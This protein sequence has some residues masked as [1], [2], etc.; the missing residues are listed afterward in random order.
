VGTSWFERVRRFKSP[1]RVVSAFL[2]RSR[3]TRARKCEELKREID[4]LRQQA[5]AQIAAR[6]RWEQQNEELRQQVR[7]LNE[8]REEQAQRTWELP[9]DPPLGTHGFGARLISLAVNLA[10]RVGLRGAQAV[11]RIVWEWLGVDTKVPCWTSI[12]NGLQRLG[13]AALTKPV[14]RAEDWIWLADHSNQIGPEKVLVVLGVRASK[15]PEPGETLKHEDVRLLAVQPGTSWKTADVAATYTQLAEQ[16]G[17]PRAVV[18]D[19]AP[20]LQDGAD[21]LKIRRSDTI[22]LRDFKPQAANA[23]QAL[24]G[25]SERFA[26]FHTQGGQTRSAIQQTELAH[27]VPPTIRQKARFMN[28]QAVLRW[29]AC[30]LWLL[31]H[32]D[33]KSRR[34]FTS[35]RLEA[36][37]G[38][39]RSFASEI[40]LWNECQPVIST[41]L[42]FLN[43]RGLFHGVAAQLRTA[44]S[45]L[46]TTDTAREL[47]ERLLTFVRDAETQLQPNERLWLSTEI[48]EST[49]GLYKQLEGQHSQGGFT[50][51]IAAFGSLLQKPTPELIREA[52][53]RVS[54]SDVK[55]WVRTNLATTLHSKRFATY[56]EFH[57]KRATL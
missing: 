53:T 48:L 27:L 13:V 29:A 14:E 37:L 28:L 3:E 21:G 25:Q 47:S 32:P 34:L 17:S 5:R 56:N 15:L 41:A 18:V 35:E 16:F 39:L 6:A 52:F 23:F 19:G 30:V 7:R 57:P 9:P 36:K 51:L 8:E 40:A 1:V 46:V 38:W 50:S 11:W 54:V 55:H 10:Q 2:L 20:E 49:F 4:D 44:L 43:E 24:L 31:D 22:V 12:R 26:E 45:A 42:T 33:A